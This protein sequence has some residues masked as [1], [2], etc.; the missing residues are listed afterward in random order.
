MKINGHPIIRQSPKDLES[1]SI[2]PDI[3]IGSLSRM[4]EFA[5]DV[6]VDE[7]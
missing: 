3:L 2:Q 1:Q 5:I 6:M 7:D 4:F